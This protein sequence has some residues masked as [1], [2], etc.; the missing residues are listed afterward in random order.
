M[1]GLRKHLILLSRSWIGTFCDNAQTQDS[2]KSAVSDKSGVVW[3]GLPKGTDLWQPVD[4]GYAQLL[5]VLMRH[6][7]E[8]WLDDDEHADLWYANENPFTAS[9]RRVLITYWGGNAYHKLCSPVYD[10][11]RIEIFVKTVAL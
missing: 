11:F 9:E 7:F 4:A 6:D 3:L 8:N 10:E 5:K 2:F 1:N